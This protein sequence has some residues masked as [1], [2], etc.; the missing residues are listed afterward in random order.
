MY[1]R[2]PAILNH[3]TQEKVAQ[4]H[5]AAARYEQ[6]AYAYQNIF[7]P[8]HSRL[9]LV[10]ILCSRLR[11]YVGILVYPLIKLLDSLIKPGLTSRGLPRLEI[12]RNDEE[13]APDLQDR[14]AFLLNDSTKMPR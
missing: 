14:Y 2:G 10:F 9:V 8:F 11:R 5:G 1:L 6:Y 7:D 4:S 13:F 12:A 3:H